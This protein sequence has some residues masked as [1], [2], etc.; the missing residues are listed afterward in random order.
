MFFL[1]K[2]VRIWSLAIFNCF[3][4][5]ERGVLLLL[6]QRLT[7]PILPPLH[8]F[9]RIAQLILSVK[10]IKPSLPKSPIAR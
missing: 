4:Y 8:D 9:H 2:D 3:D 10:P 1:N 7:A 5:F 6:L